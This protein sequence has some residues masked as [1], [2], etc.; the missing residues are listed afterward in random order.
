MAVSTL[1]EHRLAVDQYLG[2]ADFNL[3]EAHLDGNHLAVA[4]H[5]GGQ[6]I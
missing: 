4:L 5:R 2:I 6:R 3:A 1:E